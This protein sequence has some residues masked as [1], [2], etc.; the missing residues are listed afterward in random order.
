MERAGADRY[1]LTERYDALLETERV[2]RAASDRRVA[3]LLTAQNCDLEKAEREAAE[4]QRRVARLG[5]ALSRDAARHFRRLLRARTR[6]LVRRVLA[7]WLAAA[8]AIGAWQGLRA[9]EEHMR[10]RLMNQ[11]VEFQKRLNQLEMPY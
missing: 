1:A 11:S 5:E 9:A 6:E 10:L 7:R 2:A 8:C 4:Q 3:E